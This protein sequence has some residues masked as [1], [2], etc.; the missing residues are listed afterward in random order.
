MSSGWVA[1][2]TRKWGISMMPSRETSVIGSP[3]TG[4]FCPEVFV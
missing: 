3:G 2:S 4:L 1:G